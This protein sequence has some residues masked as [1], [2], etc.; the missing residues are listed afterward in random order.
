MN[1]PKTAAL[2]ISLRD[3]VVEAPQSLHRHLV[4]SLVVV[5]LR[6]ISPPQWQR[7]RFFGIAPPHHRPI[8][9]QRHH[10]G[11]YNHQGRYKLPGHIPPTTPEIRYRKS[12]IPDTHS[13]P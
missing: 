10:T 11:I 1:W 12:P 6:F 9:H 3:F 8:P 4:I 2:V 7:G 13:D 5:P